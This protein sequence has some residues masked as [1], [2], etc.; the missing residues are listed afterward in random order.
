LA[1]RAA[2]PH[3]EAPQGKLC[4]LQRLA[5]L[6]SVRTEPPTQNG[7]SPV[8]LAI[9]VFPELSGCRHKKVPTCTRA[10]ALDLTALSRATFSCCIASTTPVV[11][12]GTTADSLAN[13]L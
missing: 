10:A 9:E 8:R 11:F 6:A 4:G 7:P 1:S 2:V 12:F 3:R 13:T 5:D